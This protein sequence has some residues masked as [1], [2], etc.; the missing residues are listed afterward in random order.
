MELSSSS[1][2]RE[3]SAPQ[4][5]QQ[6]RTTLSASMTL[7]IPRAWYVRPDPATLY[8][9]EQMSNK[10]KK[11]LETNGRES[12]AKLILLNLRLPQ[13]P[14]WSGRRDKRGLPICIFDIASLDTVTTTSYG[15]DRRD[16]SFWFMIIWLVLC[17]PCARPC[18]TSQNLSKYP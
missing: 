4:S 8:Q 10:M 13:Y 2:K 7:K 11:I 1:R 15:K 14:H 12:E 3:R 16:G 6:P 18:E 17:F 5:M 9:D